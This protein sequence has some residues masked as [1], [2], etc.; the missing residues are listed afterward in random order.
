MHGNLMYILAY[1]GVAVV[2]FGL[3]IML[4]ERNFVRANNYFR[5]SY[6]DKHFKLHTQNASTPFWS[7]IKREIR[8][9]FSSSMVVLNTIVG[10]I[11][12]TIF[13]VIFLFGKDTML[14]EMELTNLDP[15]SFALIL[16]VMSSFMLGL[17]STT[18]TSISLEGK[19]FWIIKSAPLS[20]INVFWSK[21]SLNFIIALPFLVINTVAVG[22]AVQPNLIYLILMF[23]IPAMVNIANGELGLYVNLLLPRMEWDSEVRVV[24][25]SMSVIVSMLLGMALFGA[26]IALYFVLS[27]LGALLALLVVFC[28]L[29][30]VI[31]LFSMLLAT[32]GTRRYR[33][34][35]A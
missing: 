7:L 1:L 10:P 34:I 33:K 25:Q 31:V 29:A 12:S 8:R 35:K 32:D 5:V 13:V 15:D 6:T 24:K 21:I 22:I 19:T 27:F 16:I 30:L 4:V 26:L 17:I 3:F 20:E 11:M 14:V 18:G 9:Y 23:L 28:I 2:P